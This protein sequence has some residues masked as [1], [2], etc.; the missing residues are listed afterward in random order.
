MCELVEN[1]KII[2]SSLIYMLQMLC[3]IYIYF[4][5][6]GKKLMPFPIEWSRKKPRLC[7]NREIEIKKRLFSFI[8]RLSRQ[9]WNQCH[10]DVLEAKRWK[11]YY[12]YFDHIFQTCMCKI[13]EKYFFLRKKLANIRI[14]YCVI[15]RC[16]T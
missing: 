12:I 16:E 1:L 6:R 14:K 10:C 3:L 7:K 13:H 5:F 4:N 15:S 2:N 8:S 11:Y 9:G